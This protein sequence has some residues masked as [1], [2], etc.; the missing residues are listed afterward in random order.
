MSTSAP[1]AQRRSLSPAVSPL[2]LPL[3]FSALAWGLLF[4]CLP[5][6]SQNFP[7]NDDWAFGR[8]TL[9][10][11]AG[12]GIH[13][14]GWAAM[15]QLGQWLWASPFIWIL[16]QSFF[17]LRVS[18]ILLSWLGLWAFYDLLRQEGW[19][20]GRAALAVGALAFHPLFF[21]LQGT[22]MTDVPALSLALVALALYVRAVR[23]ERTAWLWAA[24][25][26]ATL[27]ALSRQNTVTVSIVAAVLLGRTP[28]L[29]TRPMWWLGVF[30]PVAAGLVTHFWFS[31]RTDV[32][33]QKPELLEP[34]SLLQLPFV[35]LHFAGLAA[36]PLLLLT[37][38]VGSWKR[39]A[40]A[41]G[42]MLA[43][44]GYWYHFDRYLPYGGLFPYTDNMLTPQG[45]FAGSK[46]SGGTLV[47]G[48]NTRPILL[49]TTS[50]VFLSLLGCVAG[51]LLVLRAIESARQARSAS[52]GP[53]QPLAG[54]PGLWLC[55]LVLF[56]IL[57]VPFLLI[58]PGIYDRY[59]LFLLPGAL[60]L[61]APPAAEIANEPAKRWA[62]PCGVVV[63]AVAGL[64]SL[65]L[66]HD[67]L[68][69]NSARWQLGQRAVEQ[70]GIDPL[71]IEGG[72]E[73]DGL[74]T[75]M[76]AKAGRPPR[77]RWPVLPFTREWF[78]WITGQYCLSFSELKDLKGKRLL[79]TQPYSLW[80]A[81]GPR[82]FYL[83][84]IL[85]L[86]AEASQSGPSRAK[87]AAE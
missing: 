42:L 36:L 54:A 76:S 80:L 4:F 66:M 49:G 21:L 17:A 10:F 71:S 18:T 81:P 3:V 47:V 38:R 39:F 41:L 27:A 31:H 8:G 68:S 40:W 19:T 23:Q 45:A 86:P 48:E 50:R 51:A 53:K 85:A 14:G 60:F 82:Q 5:P 84:E 11:A 28:A 1:V 61:A 33:V 57:Q 83:F 87:S 22:F 70:R 77:P 69:W 72:V 20:P 79:D 52:D 15:P 65:A 78:P 56:T 12:K 29:R 26:T 46:L 44:A 59:L 9:L 7:L 43:F 62:L 13:Y 34:I 2:V 63:L 25:A 16:G 64:V 37:P 30:L 67:W 75:I 58:V 74:Y 35:T 32:R 55:P 6:A 73:W 24:C